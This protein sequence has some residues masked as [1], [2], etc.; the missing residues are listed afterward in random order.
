[1]TRARALRQAVLLE[2]VS[3]VWMLAE[4]GIAV[5]SG[6]AAHS[7]ALAAFG[8]DSLIEFVTAGAV[9]WRVLTEMRVAGARPDSIRAQAAE[10]L[11]ARVVAVAL[12]TLALYIL[13]EAIPA[14][15]DRRVVTPGFWGLAVS[16]V[17]A[18]GMPFLYVAKRRVADLLG[19]EAL[20]EDATGNLACGLM[21]AIVLAGL[22]LQRWGLWWADPVAAL[23]LALLVAREGREA[24]GRAG[25]R[26]PAGTVRV[27]LGLGS[28]LGD[29]AATLGRARALLDTPDLRIVA[30]SRVYETSP[31][32]VADQPRFLNQVIEAQTRLSPRE[33]LERC[34]DLEA[35]LGRERSSRWGPRTIDVDILLYGTR[36]V[37]EP[38]LTIPH[39]QLAHRAFVLIPLAEL[40]ASARL[41]GGGTIRALLDALPDR[42]DVREYRENPAAPADADSPRAA[43]VDP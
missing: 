27:Y 7:L 21:A 5:A 28:N 22:V 30:A 17:A 23:I 20:L 43:R 2:Q 14:F 11:A 8:W 33:V 6:I 36:E 32:G 19:S 3:I 34:R 26:S 24:W 40:D 38:D 12:L 15:R 42:G 4:G 18:A 1:M 39:P 29:R 16:A 35:R 13:L 37:S 9:L 10:R 31:W 25:E 41:P